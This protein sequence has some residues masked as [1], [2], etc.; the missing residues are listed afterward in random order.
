MI[1]V[2][3]LF[4]RRKGFVLSDGGMDRKEDGKEDGKEEGK[5]DEKEERRKND[6]FDHLLGTSS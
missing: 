2:F 4:S 3:S 5:M 1:F 6:F